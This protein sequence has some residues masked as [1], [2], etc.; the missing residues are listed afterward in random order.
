MNTHSET[1]GWQL[2][3][4]SD[5]L[6]KIFGEYPSFH[7]SAIRSI[8]MERNRQSSVTFEGKPL[9]GGRRRGLVDLVLEIEHD[10]YGAPRASDY[11]V[12]VDFLDLGSS[13]IDLNAML[14]EASVM[15]ITLSKDSDGLI[16]LDLMPNV[17]LDVR[18]TCR[19]VVVRSVQPY[20]RA[21]S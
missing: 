15:D 2:A 17:G 6:L 11:L 7:D 1:W 18:L 3:T 21:E 4:N 20:V 9:S 12:V 8:C 14:E 19:E 13:Q 16:K 10:R 5:L